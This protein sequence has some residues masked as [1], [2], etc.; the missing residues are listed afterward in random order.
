MINLTAIQHSDIYLIDQILKGRFKITDKILDAGC[1][2]GRN[3]TWFAAAR[4]PI[5]GCDINE[6]SL[7]L[8][9]QNTGIDPEYFTQASLVK[10]PYEEGYFDAVICSAVLHFAQSTKEFLQMISELHRV[11]KKG[12][13]LFIR[14][15]SNFGLNN[16]YNHIGAGR[17]ELND[18]ST[19]F[20]LTPDLLKE[21][22]LKF[23]KIEPLKSVL[24]EELRSMTTLVLRKVI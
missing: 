4:I 21:I 5:Y 14:M 6:D 20:L 10:L 12:G 1:G 22:E 19:R 18:L 9:A 24:V 11:L 15:T 16:N 13:I 17:Y 2:T 23:E 3:M 8:A 7:Q